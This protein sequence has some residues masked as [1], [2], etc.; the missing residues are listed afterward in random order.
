MRH[1]TCLI[2]VL[3]HVAD[4]ADDF[5]RLVVRQIEVNDFADRIGARPEGLRQR[6]VDDGHRRA[7]RQIA[8]RKQPAALEWNPERLE[9][10]G[11]PRGTTRQ[12]RL[13]PRTP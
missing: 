3:M 1:A 7:A 6:R 2:Q 11:R 4:D 5:P 12:T 8:T 10:V 9:V 13:A